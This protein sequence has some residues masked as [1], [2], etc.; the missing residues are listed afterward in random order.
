MNAQVKLKDGN[1]YVDLFRNDEWITIADC[2]T[3]Q[4]LAIEL[5]N[6]IR[7]NDISDADSKSLEAHY[8]RGNRYINHNFINRHKSTKNN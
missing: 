3:N 7:R 2:G 6:H 1:Y 4:S 5:K 8:K